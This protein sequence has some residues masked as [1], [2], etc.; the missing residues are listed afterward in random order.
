M[1]RANLFLKE[2]VAGDRTATAQWAYNTTENWPAPT[3]AAK[4]GPL[5]TPTPTAITTYAT[6]TAYNPTLVGTYAPGGTP[7]SEPGQGHHYAGQTKP[8]QGANK[9]NNWHKPPKTNPNPYPG[10]VAYHEVWRQQ[11][12]EFASENDQAEWGY[13]YYATDNVDTL[14]YQA[15]SDI[16]TRSQFINYGYLLNTENDTFRG[17]DTD[18]PTFGFARDLGEVDSSQQ[19]VLFQISLHQQNCVMFEDSRG[20]QSIPCMLCFIAPKSLYRETLLTDLQAC[21]PTTLTTPPML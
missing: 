1:Y 8:P 17:I 18:Y 15:A 11:Q 20:N 5:E 13:W 6:S 19:S 21:G 4:N 9:H 3:W 10:G 2:W 16:T 12:L 7:V 14:T